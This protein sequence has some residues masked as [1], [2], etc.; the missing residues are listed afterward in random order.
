M[1]DFLRD[2]TRLLFAI[3]IPLILAS[4]V[5]VGT[6][7]QPGKNQAPVATVG[8]D[9]ITQAE[10]ERA[11]QQR[12]SRVRA[13]VPEL[14]ITL[15]DTPAFRQSVVDELV[16]QRLLARAV[17]EF[18]INVTDDRLR[19]IFASDQQF[20][21]LRNPDGRINKT[22]IEGS[23]FRSTAAFEANLRQDLAERQVM[24]GMLV[25]RIASQAISKPALDAFFQQREVQVLHFKPKDY[26]SQVAVTDAELEVFYRDPEISARFLVPEQVDLEYVVFD[27][28]AVAKDM[29]ISE[30]D[31]KS[32]Y[33][34]NLT[35]F[36]SPQE[37]RVRHILIAV[38]QDAQPDLRQRSRAKAEDLLAQLQKNPGSFGELAK[39]ESQDAGSAKVGGDLGFFFKD[40]VIFGEALFALESGALSNVIET[41]QGFHIIQMT[42]QRGGSV[43]SFDVVRT[44]ILEEVRKSQAQAKF[45]DLSQEFSHMVYEQGDT[46]QAVVDKWKLERRTI[47]GLTRQG[48]RDPVLSH[49]KLLEAV[50][51]SDALQDKRNTPAIEVSAAQMVSARVLKHSSARQPALSE[52]LEA[53]RAAFVVKASAALARKEGEKSLALN[54][55]TPA[56]TFNQKVESVSRVKPGSLSPPL[57]KRVLSV[58]SAKLPTVVSHDLGEQGYQLALITRILASDVPTADLKVG[59]AEYAQVWEAAESQ[60]YFDA[61]K[62]RFKVE[63]KPQK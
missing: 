11:H 14:D 38:A 26:V 55:A 58:P 33:N 48:T 29:V 42:D 44:E 8:R 49:P 41:E 24:Q 50:F 34:N 16:R 52:V 54:Q 27:T 22:L 36:G 13:Q 9:E 57:L 20:A 25:S 2:H 56:A 63:A 28:A 3:L 31:L 45:S 7:D 59:Q 43:R 37:R 61:L 47:A 53:V 17:S 15:V 62:V 51:A 21:F 32:Y 6:F 12:L 30:D 4:F 18:R 19:R 39:K 5:L 23:S 40:Q 60:S 46:L 1:F 35:R 10:F